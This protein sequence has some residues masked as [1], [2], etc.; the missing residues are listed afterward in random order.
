MSERSVVLMGG[1]PGSGSTRLGKSLEGYLHSIG[2][3][4]EHTSV[5]D[6]IRRI[7]AGM[8]RSACTAEVI[9]HLNSRPINTPIDDGIMLQVVEEIFSASKESS[10]ILLDGYPRYEPQIDQVEEVAESAKRSIRGMLATVADAETCLARM[11]K[12]GQKKP[13]RTLTLEEAVDRLAAH[14][15]AFPYVLEKLASH[16]IA[17]AAIETSGS[18]FAADRAGIKAVHAL[19][20]VPTNKT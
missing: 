9:A 15:M 3:S 14:N 1:A 8:I 10:I 16:C 12:R 13:E 19:V 18:K 11:V 5:G 17:V 6:R 4:A 20:D 7:G 2:V